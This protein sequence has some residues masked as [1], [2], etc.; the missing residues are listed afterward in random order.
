GKKA[1]YRLLG[2]SEG[3]FSFV[4]GSPSPLRRVES[5]TNFLLME[6]M[7]QIDEAR[8]RRASIAAEQDALLAI[9]PAASN[10]PD[11]ALRISEV[12]TAPRTLDELLDEVP[13]RD[14]EILEAL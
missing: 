12:L 4:G 6:G 2:E 10:A 1:L 5:S 13:H 14:L 3:T 11:V 9:A 8:S 7:R